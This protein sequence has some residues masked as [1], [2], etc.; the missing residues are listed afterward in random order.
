MRI[1]RLDLT[2]YGHFTDRVI[3]FGPRSEGVPDF[4]IIHGANE[5]GKSTIFSAWLDFLYGIDTRSTYNFLHDYK[6]MRVGALVET[7]SGDHDLIRVKKP[8]GSLLD[9]HEQ[10]VGDSVLSGDLGGLA[11]DSY[12]SMFSLDEASLA[13]GGEAILASKGEVGQLL[14]SASAGLSDLAGRLDRIREQT[15][16]FHRPRAQKSD[17]ADLKRKLDELKAERDAIDI[18]ASEHARLVAERDR[19]RSAHDETN[20]RRAALRVQ[21]EAATARLAALPQLGRLERLR[22]ELTGLGDVPQ[23]RSGWR[24]EIG[25]LTRRQVELQTALSRLDRDMTTIDAGISAAPP[26]DPLLDRAAELE[27]LRELAGRA[28]S[29]ERDLPNR[30]DEKAASN[31]TIAA[32]TVRLGEQNREDPR[33]LL[34]PARISGELRSLMARHS[35]IE[36]RLETAIGEEASAMQALEDAKAQWLRQTGGQAVA[37]PDPQRLQDL[38]DHLAALRA[39]DLEQRQSSA[40]RVVEE[41]GH[42]LERRVPLLSPWD[43]DVEA[44]A[45]IIAPAPAV[46]AQL[47]RRLADSV[48]KVR[49]VDGELDGLKGEL[50]TLEADHAVA[51]G[52]PGIVTDGAADA[53]R[54]ERERS[55]VEHRATMDA[56][57]AERFRDALDAD[58]R[59]SMQR[60]THVAEITRLRGLDQSIARL[61][62]RLDIAAGTGAKAREIELSIRQQL[63][64]L[65]E[66]TDDALPRD[67]EFAAF[68]S[69]CNRLAAAQE[70]GEALLRARR[71]LEALRRTTDVRRRDLSDTVQGL[72]L[73][74]NEDDLS[75]L[76]AAAR[77]FLE[78]ESKRAALREAMRAGQ[79]ELERRRGQRAESQATQD[80]WRDA[81]QQALAG[82]WLMSRGT[83]PT[84]SEME[85]VLRHL[86]A[87]E[88]E[89]D[90]HDGLAD[91]I[92][93]MERDIA[94]FAGEARTL[95]TD[96]GLAV[97]VSPHTLYREISDRHDLARKED[98]RVAELLTRRDALLAER[99]DL[100]QQ[101]ETQDARV[102]RMT[103]HFAV[104]TLGEVEAKIALSERVAALKAEISVLEAEIAGSLGITE[105][106]ELEVLAA[107]TDRD[108]LARE[109]ETLK[110][111]IDTLDHETAQAYADLS[112]AERKL[113]SLGSDGEAA[114]L[115]E[116][117]RTVLLEIED[118]A[119]RYLELRL[120]AIATDQALR[121]YR[122]R[123]QSSMMKK[124]SEAFAQLSRGNYRTLASQRDGQREVLVAIGADGSSKEAQDLSK[125][126]QFQLYLALRVAGYQEAAAT[127]TPV[128]FI[129]DDIMESFDEERSEEAL[130]QLS[131][132]ARSGQVIYLTHHKH[133]CDIATAVCPS[134]SIHPL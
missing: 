128:P 118:G 44:L 91:R 117:R 105:L 43:G 132:M 94:N 29:E 59:V 64:A 12:R 99:D 76:V 124:A 57:S 9:R 40:E 79:A 24:Q 39:V 62:A 72:G 77:R 109:I 134:V 41:A 13:E 129:A 30:M 84:V 98:D 55:W 67:M 96:L 38:A 33:Q 86:A 119:R 20:R 17:L 61:R 121:L 107:G 127:R 23:T 2:R 52:T 112:A 19:S 1:R 93:K 32:I 69:W 14:F 47:G 66:D 28:L 48:E 75:R 103:E 31:R 114:R 37:E 130:T 102:H 11:R 7:A 46:L 108:E 3:D 21:L 49:Q 122:D 56:P 4:H 85:E 51:A 113:G 53:T 116:A 111:Q 126:T 92:A 10:T 74:V 123:H 50:S 22:A 45:R 97:D 89:L 65:I 18:V 34:L 88:V 15:D 101:G 5:A 70:A 82:N 104:E 100:L 90:R 87:L 81:W 68:E 133:I 115:S 106:A 54:A 42:Q 8:A 125:G 120:G 78:G 36:A 35:G 26:R 60:L 110:P 71:D 63:A 73:D 58:D 25:E 80:S 95:A 6:M 131:T 27:A 83:V 16:Q